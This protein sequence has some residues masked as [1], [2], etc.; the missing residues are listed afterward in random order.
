MN[1]YNQEDDS[2]EIT[3]FELGLKSGCHMSDI[4]QALE[5]YK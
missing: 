2:V 5:T 4:Q 1:T 3:Y